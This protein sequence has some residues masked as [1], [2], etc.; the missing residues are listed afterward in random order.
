MVYFGA[1]G[2]LSLRFRARHRPGSSRRCG[3]SSA[4]GGRMFYAPD[5]AKFKVG[6]KYFLLPSALGRGQVPL[7]AA[8]QFPQLPVCINGPAT[9]DVQ[10][11]RGAAGPRS[12]FGSP[13]PR[14]TVVHSIGCLGPNLEEAASGKARPRKG[15]HLL[16]RPARQKRRL[17][18]GALGRGSE[19]SLQIER[20]ETASAPRVIRN[21][22]SKP[23]LRI[24]AWFVCLVRYG[25]CR[26]RRVGI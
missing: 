1:L 25:R 22:A 14:V 10:V 16:G 26:Q 5:D 19:V 3:R 7:I 15:K 9:P 23:A 6:G 12:P 18:A 8:Q 11:M 21:K 17:A 2:S 24:S 20:I 13:R 4:V